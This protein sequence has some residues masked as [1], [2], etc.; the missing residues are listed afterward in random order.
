[1]SAAYFYDG[2]VRED[3]TI[4]AR[5][6]GEENGRKYTALWSSYGNISNLGRNSMALNPPWPVNHK[7]EDDP[8]QF[9]RNIKKT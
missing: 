7:I 1:M 9:G 6:K 5:V 2:A 8:N 3:T 4:T